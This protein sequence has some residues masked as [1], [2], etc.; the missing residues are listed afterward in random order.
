M[1]EPSGK[2]IRTARAFRAQATYFRRIGDGTIADALLEAAD[3]LAPLVRDEHG[4]TGEQYQFRIDVY[5]PDHRLPGEI[6]S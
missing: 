2:D 3:A 6:G 5:D 1:L 4:L